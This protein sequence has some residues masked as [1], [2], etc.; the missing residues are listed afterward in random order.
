MK[1]QF[2]S[3]WSVSALDKKNKLKKHGRLRLLIQVCFAALSNGYLA[4]FAHGRI[5]QGASKYICTPGLN[6]YSCPGA[7]ASCPIGALQ[8]TLT[9]KQFHV[10]LYALG[11]ITVFGTI[12]GRVICGFL[13][14]FGLLQDLLFR[15]PFIKKLRRLPGERFLRFLRFAF[16]GIFVI[17]L[18]MVVADVVGIGDPW[19]CKYVCPTGTIEGGIPLVLMNE[20]LR[21]AIGFLYTWKL[22]I[23][24][25]ILLLSIILFR[26][27]C[28]YIC[29]L[30]AIYG[31]FNKISF[32]KFKVDEEKCIKCGAC[33]KACKLDI[34]VWKDPNSIDCIRCGDCKT[35]CPT[36]AIQNAFQTK[37]SNK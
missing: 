25:V 11:M 33:Q 10:S 32:T 12:F 31:L 20:G 15:I 28:R 36:G 2:A 19:F 17:L 13:C 1:K 21:S 14:P 35:V 34:S 26:P 29:P 24:G 37:K 4:G 3:V 18:P 5:F 9:S 6:C 22:V 16:L 23:L 7:L 30:G 8:A 27:F